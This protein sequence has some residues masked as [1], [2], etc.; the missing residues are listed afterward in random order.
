[1]AF[2]NVKQVGMYQAE[3]HTPSHVK[4]ARTSSLRSGRVATNQGDG[5]AKLR[6][7]SFDDTCSDCRELSSMTLLM[8]IQRSLN[9]TC[10]RTRKILSV[11]DARLHL[12]GAASCTLPLTLP[13]SSRGGERACLRL[14]LSALAL[15]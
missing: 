7:T 13:N 9:T 11:E 10:S 14:L 1:M 15:H 5:L 8:Y 3:Q 2:N 6:V 4:Y 12:P